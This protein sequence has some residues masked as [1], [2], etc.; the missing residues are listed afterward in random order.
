MRTGLGLLTLCCTLSRRVSASQGR[1]HGNEGHHLPAGP[2]DPLL[3]EQLYFRGIYR[4]RE[5]QHAG[6]D[7]PVMVPN[8]PGPDATAID[9][10]QSVA[11]LQAEF[12][13]SLSVHTWSFKM[14]PALLQYA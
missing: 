14:L 12:S 13:R 10:R 2:P 3:D 4:Q 6:R 11:S 5:D 8:P 7:G 9:L 1:E